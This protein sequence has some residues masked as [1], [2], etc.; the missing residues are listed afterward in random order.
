MYN[1]RYSASADNEFGHA[2]YETVD[3]K[4]VKVTNAVPMDWDKPICDKWPDKKFVGVGKRFVS[5]HK[6]DPIGMPD[7]DAPESEQM[8]ACERMLQYI[9]KKR[10]E[11][12]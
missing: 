2:I 5:S 10:A 3:D 8:A 9:H 11:L 12:N 4:H 1:L 6:K 7:F